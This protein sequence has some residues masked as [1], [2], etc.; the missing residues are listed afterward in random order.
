MDGFNGG[1]EGAKK[2]INRPED[3]MTEMTQCGQQTEMK[4]IKRASEACQA[5]AL[6]LV[7][8]ESQKKKRKKAGLEKRSK[9]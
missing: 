2:R 8:A 1:I 9:K 3:R 5:Q 4:K 6:S 7:P